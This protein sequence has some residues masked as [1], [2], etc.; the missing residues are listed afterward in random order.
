MT[1]GSGEWEFF[2]HERMPLVILNFWENC[3]FPKLSFLTLNMLTRGDHFFPL[4]IRLAWPVIR[5]SCM[6]AAKS[7][8]ILV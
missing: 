2:S 6:V 3:Y 8:K 5:N 4:N 1:R 7:L